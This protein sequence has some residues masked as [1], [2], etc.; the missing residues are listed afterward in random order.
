MVRSLCSQLYNPDSRLV[1]RA[2]SLQVNRQ[3]ESRDSVHLL[4]LCSWGI[5]AQDTARRS[6][7]IV[8]SYREIAS[9]TW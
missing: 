5:L 4:R 7:A 3:N 8:M 2:V 6:D 1:D 9:A